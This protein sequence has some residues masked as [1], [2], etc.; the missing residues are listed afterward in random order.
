MDFYIRTR[1]HLV[2][3][4]NYDSIDSTEDS[5]TRLLVRDVIDGIGS[6]DGYPHETASRF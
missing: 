3:Q 4:G 2:D 1:S 5:A 6:Q